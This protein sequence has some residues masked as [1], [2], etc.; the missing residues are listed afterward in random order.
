MLSSQPV[1]AGSWQ[2][3]KI[4]VQALVTDDV[5]AV[6]PVT[7]AW[8]ARIKYGVANDTAHVTRQFATGD[9]EGWSKPVFATLHHRFSGEEAT[10]YLGVGVGYAEGLV[11]IPSDVEEEEAFAFKG[12]FGTELDL[13]EG[14]GAFIEYGFAVAPKAN[15]LSSSSLRSHS[16]NTGFTL[17]LN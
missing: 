15:G 14:L 12:V 16:L 3:T 13:E 8:G 2:P 5:Q 1:L 4:H 11:T 6:H 9:E 17:D 7:N 10:H